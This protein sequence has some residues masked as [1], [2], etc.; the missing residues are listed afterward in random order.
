MFQVCHLQVLQDSKVLELIV[1]W[2]VNNYV[3]LILKF[4]R[5]LLGVMVVGVEYLL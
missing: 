4:D 3:F 1:D 2:R 5:L